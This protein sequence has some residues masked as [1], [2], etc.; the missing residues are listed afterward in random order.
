MSDVEKDLKAAKIILGYDNEIDGIDMS[1][2]K[3]IYPW[4]NEYI[5]NYYNYVDLNEKNSL[6]ITG[7]GDHAIYACLAGSKL[8]D[9]VDIN[10]LAKYYSALKIAMIRTYDIKTLKR[11]ININKI[12]NLKSPPYINRIDTFQLTNYL[13]D[14]ELFFWN[15]LIN[16]KGFFDNNIFR[17]DGFYFKDCVPY[18]VKNDELFK[19]LQAN[20]NIC[21]ISYHDMDIS[22]K[23]I[24]LP[25]KYDCVF[26]S[27]VLE[28]LYFDCDRLNAVENCESMLNENGKI[29]TYR[30]NKSSDEFLGKYGFNV[31]VGNAVVLSNKK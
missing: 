22:D 10:P 2:Y 1:F 11:K 3:R 29:I 21:K 30:L 28:H 25:N 20:L 16:K 27:N 8:I 9:S 18:Y 5:E 6:T 17:W 12:K 23:M 4:T 7:S 14:E 15:G 31:V 24:K 26:L 13:T 19:R